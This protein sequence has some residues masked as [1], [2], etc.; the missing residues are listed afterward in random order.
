[1]LN[2]SQRKHLRGIA[3]GLRPLVQIGRKGLTEGLLEGMERALYGHEL[4]KVQ[5]LDFKDRK[6]ELCEE[7]A[8]RSGS[9]WVGLIGHIGTFYRHHSDPDKR[10]IEVPE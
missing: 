3:H 6:M 10:R 7:L 1:M 2:S 9:E 5:F 4:V 8:Q